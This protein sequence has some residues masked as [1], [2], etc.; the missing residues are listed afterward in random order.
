MKIIILKIVYIFLLNNIL[1]T[2]GNL[3]EIEITR[4][5]KGQLVFA[6]VVSIINI[7]N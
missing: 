1:V 3:S 5:T 2:C 4:K 7:I 6:H